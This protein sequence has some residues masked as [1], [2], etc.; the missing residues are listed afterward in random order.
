MADDVQEHMAA[1]M[2]DDWGIREEAA[3]ALG[4]LGDPRAVPPLVAALKDPDR[5]VRAAAIRALEAIGTPSVP[6][7][8]QC[9]R[10]PDLSVQEA[11][12]AVLSTIGD[13]RIVEHLISALESPD[14]IVRMY[15]AKGLGRIGDVRAIEPLCGLLQDQVK[16]VREDGASALGALGDS[17]VQ[18]L[19]NMLTNNEWL[20]RLRAVEALGRAKSPLA[21]EPLLKLLA[22]DSDVAVRQDA[23]R[24]LGEI[25]DSRAFEALLRAV[26]DIRLRPAAVE[27]LGKIGDRRAVGPLRSIVDE[28]ARS[29]GEWEAHGCRNERYE[30]ELPAVEAAVKALG[31]IGDHAAIPT[32]V[33]ALKSTTVRVEAG[34][35]LAGFGQPAVSALLAVLKT[36]QDENILFHVRETLSRLG[37]RAGRL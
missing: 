29:Q 18:V 27:A 8:G 17:A 20:T 13:E 36:E 34:D 4:E 7:L 32:L 26:G 14:W 21:V 6:T 25:G 3:V 1:L 22:D 23:A 19:V 28:A 2:D 5:A 16:A 10:D 31:R 12:A 11:A 37:W 30:Q 24:A 35:A 33:T 9:L 15:A